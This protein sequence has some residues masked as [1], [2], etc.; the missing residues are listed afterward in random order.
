MV[1]MGIIKNQYIIIMIAIILAT[2]VFRLSMDYK[3]IT[4]QLT[5]KRPAVT[6][7]AVASRAPNF[8]LPFSSVAADAQ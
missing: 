3:N 6:V 7:S 8:T 2:V 4:N 5:P 1:G